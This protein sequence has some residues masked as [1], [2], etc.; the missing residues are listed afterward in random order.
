MNKK[1]NAL[2]FGLALAI[3]SITQ[4][5]TSVG[6]EGSVHD[7]STNSIYTVWNT[8]NGVCSPCHSAHN[9]DPAQIAPLWNHATTTTVFTKYSS[10]TLNASVG[11]PSGVSLACL[12]C[13]DG[14]VGINQSIGST[15]APVIIDAQYIIGGGT[16]DLHTTHPISFTYD[17][18]L[19]TAD[20]ELENPTTY[21]IGDTKTKLTINVAPVP[22]A[23]EPGS[24]IK[25]K[26]I[27]EAMLF[28][29][30]M[31]CASCHDVH[32]MSG[33]APN[34]GILVRLTGNDATG[35]GSIICRTCHIK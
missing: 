12:S 2:V 6:I 14:T 4:A 9:T 31:E 30:K 33:Y 19:A 20:G 23:A 16:G 35:R 26:T 1:L 24:V 3:P 18:A 10:P 34:S 17:A 22:T 25:G 15:N 21:K 7:M 13:H 5:A 8:R 27:D 11:A 32:K 28:N 29:H